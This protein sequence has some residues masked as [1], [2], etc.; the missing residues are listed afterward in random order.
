MRAKETT[1]HK[2]YEKELDVDESMDELRIKV[3]LSWTSPT[4]FM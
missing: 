1:V 4:D 2:L 3:S